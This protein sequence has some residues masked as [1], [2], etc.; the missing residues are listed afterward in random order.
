MEEL[1]NAIDSKRN[2]K[3]NSLNAYLISIKKIHNAIFGDKEMKNI[4]FLKDEDKV[5][6]SFKN[7]KLNT[8][9]NY[10]SSIIVSLDAMNKDGEYDK[11]IKVYRDNLEAVNKV[12][13]E[14]LSKNEKSESQEENWV[15]LK[16]LKKVL[17]GYKS[18]LVDRGVFKKDELTKK[19]MDILQRW[20]VGN[21]YIGDD[22]NPPPR[23]DF[24]MDIIKNSDYEKLSDEDLN[25][26]NY[27]VIKSRTNK[28]FH[29]SQY[30]TNKTQGIKKIPVGK[31]LNSVLNIWLKYNPNSYLLMDSHGKRMSS[32]QLSK[33]INK[34]FAPTGKK[35]TANLLR[36]IYIS[37]KF[38]VEETS[39]KKAVASK[40][41]H[42]VD[43][44]G[45]YA[46]K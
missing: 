21:L 4:D 46:K 23:L 36:H 6:E 45:T 41:G 18:D 9:K 34:V 33:Y 42:S 2:I 35:I 8:Q 7:L 30:K 16:D 11:D 28:F 26:N 29:F 13:Y 44:Q 22:A 25:S 19:Q 38:P 1:K 12:F 40:M 14:E 39:N 37:T 17:N 10:L 20:V 32:N 3:A 43:T 15:S 5:L 24:D 27:L 31:T